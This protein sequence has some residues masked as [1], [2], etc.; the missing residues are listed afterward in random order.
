M[1][2]LKTVNDYYEIMTL[3]VYFEFEIGICR[4]VMQYI[5]YIYCDKII[6]KQ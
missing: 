4:L 3:K 2:L 6:T 1:N 5:K